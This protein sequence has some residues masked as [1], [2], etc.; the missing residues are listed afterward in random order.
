MGKLLIGKTTYGTE[1][2]LLGW[3]TTIGAAIPGNVPSWKGHSLSVTLCA[4]NMTDYDSEKQG[5]HDPDAAP[6]N[7]A[8]H[9]LYFAGP[10]PAGA[11]GLTLPGVVEQGQSQLSG[12]EQVLH[13]AQAEPLICAVEDWLRSPWDPAPVKDSALMPSGFR[14]VVRDPALAPP[15]TVLTLPLRALLTPPPQAL[16]PP[17]L[18]WATHSAT[19]VLGAVPAEALAR[20]QTGALL[21]LPASFA[22]AWQ[23]QLLDEQGDLPPCLAQLDL[24]AQRL[25]VSASALSPSEWPMAD[26]A[27]RVVLTHPVQLPLDQWLGWG[28]GA[29]PYHW[30]VPQ[31][32]TAELRQGEHVLARGALLPVGA[33]CGLHVEWLMPSEDMAHM[34]T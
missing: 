4:C 27:P 29:A 10:G 26:E 28:R 8:C 18:T 34:P 9:L 7:A 11:M 16:H 17:A 23:V 5:L 33:G 25:T 32:W 14:A 15:G 19:M 6:L 12:A 21:W 22:S 13:L 30:P 2:S 31:P 24:A 3:P 1:A 20:L